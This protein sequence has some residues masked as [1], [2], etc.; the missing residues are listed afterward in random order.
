MIDFPSYQY[1]IPA[2]YRTKDIIINGYKKMGFSH[3]TINGCDVL[4]SLDGKDVEIIFVSGTCCH[5]SSSGNIY[6][7]KDFAQ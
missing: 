1:E 6:L 2:E 7:L 4:V 3:A 5:V